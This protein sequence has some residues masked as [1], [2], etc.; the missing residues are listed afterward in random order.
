M[1]ANI[2]LLLTAV[3]LLG[4]VLAL[5]QAYRARLRQFEAM[6]VQRYWDILDRLSL[7]ALR[8]RPVAAD[9]GEGDQKAIRAYVRLCEDELEL[10]ARGS[11]SDY[12]YAIWAAGIRD[13]LKQPMFDQVWEQIRAEQTF[14]YDRLSRLLEEGAGHDPCRMPRWR[15]G[16]RGLAG[17]PGV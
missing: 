7:E 12:T 9:I 4:A 14:P 10:R 16:L 17:S 11:I 15:R 13:Q 8:G 1:V 2:G 3:G 5:R 6:F